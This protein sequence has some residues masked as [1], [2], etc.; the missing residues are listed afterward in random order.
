MNGETKMAQS[1]QPVS[2]ILVLRKYILKFSATVHTNQKEERFFR[3]QKT[4][5]LT[6]FSCHFFY[7]DTFV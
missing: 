1:S 4:I 6:H 5:D 2:S 3:E 7:L